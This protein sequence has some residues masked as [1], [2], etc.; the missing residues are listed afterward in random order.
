MLFFND[1]H[2]KSDGE[3]IARQYDN[4]SRE[5]VVTGKIPEGYGWQLLVQ[6]NGQ[7]NV[8]TLA[9]APEGLS[10]LLT[11]EMLACSGQYAVQVRG[12]QGELVKHTNVVQVYVPESMSGDVEWPTL[13]TE[14]SQAEARIRELQS[15]PPIPGEDGVWRLWNLQS[16]AYDPSSLP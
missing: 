9:E 10:V 2:L 14:F 4:L 3:L 11:A 8:I 16:E 1:W 13:P 5:L 15:H 6:C 7:L 12:I